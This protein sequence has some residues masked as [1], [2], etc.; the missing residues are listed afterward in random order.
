M[1]SINLLLIDDDDLLR[2]NME[3]FLTDEGFKVKSASNAEAALRLLDVIPFDV[4]IVDI[5][6]PG[7]NGEEF[8]Y[9]AS[10]I[11][12]KLKFLIYT[13]SSDYK[14]TKE[15]IGIGLSNENVF[16][17]PINDMNIFI[18]KINQLVS[19]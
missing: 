13:G 15:M 7:M 8:I 1:K 19:E 10:K 2:F 16:L 6:L 5:R 18:S 3:M 9:T 17:K 14:V 12:L 11:N 4:A